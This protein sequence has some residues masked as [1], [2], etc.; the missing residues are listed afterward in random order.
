M[1]AGVDASS[2]GVGAKHLISFIHDWGHPEWIVIAAEA[3]IDKVSDTY[4][5]LR[6]A[7]EVFRRVQVKPARKKDT[8]IAPLVAI[9]RPKHS[10]WSI[11]FRSLCLPIQERDVNEAA[12][13]ALALSAKLKTRTATFCGADTSYSMTLSLFAGG[14]LIEQKEWHQAASPDKSFQA[15]G[16]YLPACFPCRAEGDPWLATQTSSHDT[17]EET[18]ILNLEPLRAKS[19]TIARV[20]P[21]EAKRLAPKL[22]R[23]A[24]AGNLAQIKQLIAAGA[25]VNR[26]G[27]TTSWDDFTP[28]IAAASKGR[29]AAVK[30]L[31]AEGAELDLPVSSED[32]DWTGA[33][34]LAMAA[35]NGHIDVVKEL[36]KEG[37]RVKFSSDE[38]A[39][40]IQ[41]AAET[42]RLPIVQALLKAG[43]AVTQHALS[44][45]I[46]R[47]LR[48][49]N[50][51]LLQGLLKSGQR[52][53][54]TPSTV[55]HAIPTDAWP[56][57]KQA[58]LAEALIKAGADINGDNCA[59]LR[60]CITQ[61]NSELLRFLMK[62]GALLNG[63]ATGPHTPLHYAA[64]S[65]W[66]D[67]AR[68][69][70]QAGA[71]L[72][73]TNCYGQTPAEWAKSQ[74]SKGVAKF[75]SEH[76]RSF[77]VG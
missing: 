65:D 41:F 23:A 12:K 31:L 74:G 76:P 28:L 11:I 44:R 36:L 63:S 66:V 27:D 21:Q 59:A 72:D 1:K 39:T 52:L 55:S 54:F 45:A 29:V 37:A 19:R 34:A 64:L 42:D 62:S 47:A 15:A 33:T 77:R 38:F 2:P 57:H 69:L 75:L 53:P 25:D 16:L 70:V 60:N 56:T 10:S 26:S 50:L 46:K 71:K 73:A 14:K 6:G 8:E 20:S 49:G 30:L 40:A 51:K 58:P 32:S 3:P 18:S 9:A 61:R 43:A 17:I 22:H 7:T 68:I 24:L 35:R 48:T 67:G 13:D 4:A 5:R